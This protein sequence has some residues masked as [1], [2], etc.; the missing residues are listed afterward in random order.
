MSVRYE[1]DEETRRANGFSNSTYKSI[2]DQIE[3]GSEGKRI[4]IKDI[5]YYLL[6]PD[7][8]PAKLAPSWDLKKRGIGTEPAVN[9]VNGH[10][11]KPPFPYSTEGEPGNPT[12]VPKALLEKFHFTFLIRDPHS[13]IP[14]YYRC[15]IPPLDKMTGFYEFYP[16]EAGYDELRRFFDYT[17]EAGL[18][19]NRIAGETHDSVNGGADKPEICMI[20]ADDLLDDPEGILRVYC[21]SV[22]LEFTHDML[23]WDNE[24][25]HARAKAAFEKWKGFHEDAIDSKDLKPRTHRKAARTE[26][27]WDA[28]WKEKYG[29]KAA[30]VIRDTVDANMADYHYLKQF[31]L[32]K[33]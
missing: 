9:G 23:N 3:E 26:A 5:T 16:S 12:I 1:N 8:Q 25:D 14:S 17:R 11:N 7:Q 19:A 32:K 13:S 33:P 31:V 2:F 28:E 10:S 30:K 6:P 24:E 27:E 4:F 18:V 29:E 20:D 21:K 15:C 22:G